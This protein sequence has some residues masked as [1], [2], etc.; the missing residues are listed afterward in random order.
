MVYHSLDI[1]YGTLVTWGDLLKLGYVTAEQDWLEVDNEINGLSII[2]AGHHSWVDEVKE[3]HPQRLPSSYRAFIGHEDDEELQGILDQ[4]THPYMLFCLCVRAGQ[5]DLDRKAKANY[6]GI[7][8]IVQAKNKF[9]ECVAGD[10]A[11]S[12]ML[13]E[14]GQQTLHYLPDDCICCT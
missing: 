5:I 13:P 8:E 11:L 14:L 1:V 3:N 2:Y 12:K 9:E 6:P 7:N 10:E 4:N